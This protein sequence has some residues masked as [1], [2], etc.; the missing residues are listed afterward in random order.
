VPERLI[1]VPIESLPVVDEHS[2]SIS[3]SAEQAWDALLATLAQGF[4]NTATGR[5][6]ARRLGCIPC[7]AKGEPDRIG[8][9]IPGF[10][11]TRAIPPAVLALMGEHRYSR[12][13]LVFRITERDDAPLLLSAETRAEFPGRSGTAYRTL[14][15][16]TRGHVLAT[17]SLLRAIRRSAERRTDGCTNP[18]DSP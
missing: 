3:A 16:G 15:I 8:S 18:G 7:D 10:I 12:Y 1:D 11:V 14:V 4:S 13:A 17:R 9:T 5:A 2:V 6:A